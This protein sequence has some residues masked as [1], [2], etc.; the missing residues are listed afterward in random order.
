[1]GSRSS[2]QPWAF[3]SM[4]TILNAGMYKLKSWKIFIGFQNQEILVSASNAVTVDSDTLP[5]PVGNGTTLAGYPQADLKTSVDTAGDLTQIQVQFELYGTQ[6]VIRPPGYPMPRTIR[7]VNDGYKYPSPRHIGDQ[8]PDREKDKD[9]GN[10][11]YCCRNGTLF[12]NTMNETKS[13]SVFRLQYKCGPVIRVDDMV[14]PDPTGLQ[15]TS[16]AIAS[17][18][19]VCNIT[20]PKI[21]QARCCASYSAYYNES[22]IPCN[23]CACGCENTQRKCNPNAQALILPPETLL[24]PF[25]NRTEK[26]VT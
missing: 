6:F 4:A 16:T 18:Q 22:V 9:V 24:V 10:L 23:T 11:L 5:A 8:P 13:V 12:P 14:S 21:R 25:E 2:A 19:V 17:W 26:A 7:L 15:A 1:M 3:K 20:R